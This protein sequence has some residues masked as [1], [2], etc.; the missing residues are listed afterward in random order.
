MIILPASVNIYQE[1]KQ[2]VPK[3][4]GPSEFLSLIHHCE[5]VVTDSFHGS[6]FSI[7]YNKNFYSFLKKETEMKHK[8]TTAELPIC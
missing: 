1:Y 8:A 7:N 2:Y 4:I 6:I 5:Y 3:G